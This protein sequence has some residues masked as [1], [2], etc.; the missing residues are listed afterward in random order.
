PAPEPA[1]SAVRRG[2]PASFRGS[3]WRGDEGWTGQ[4]SRTAPATDSESQIAESP[5]P[6]SEVRPPANPDSAGNRVRIRGDTGPVASS[7]RLPALAAV[8]RRDRTGSPPL[9]PA[10]L[11]TAHD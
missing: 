1:P 5:D 6:K 9:G 7:V 3:S 11:D 10:A 4:Q 2:L 8:M